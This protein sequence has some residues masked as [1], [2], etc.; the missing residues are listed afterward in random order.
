M[1]YVGVEEKDHCIIGTLDEEHKPPSSPR[2]D[3]VYINLNGPYPNFIVAGRE[4]LI[5]RKV[6]DTINI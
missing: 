5:F 3:L 4:E 1:I 6:N 2:L